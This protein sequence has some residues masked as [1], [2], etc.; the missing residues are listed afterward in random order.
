MDDEPI[1]GRSFHNFKSLSFSRVS[2]PD[3]SYPFSSTYGDELSGNVQVINEYKKARALMAD[4][5]ATSKGGV[6]QS[7]FQEVEK[8]RPMPRKAHD[9]HA[10]FRYSC[11]DRSQIWQVQLTNTI[12]DQNVHISEPV[13]VKD[14]VV[15]RECDHAQALHGL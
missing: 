5:A 11:L 14:K 9:L 10:L 7:L 12:C 2:M 3:T 1:H 13:F 15:I 4:S 8:V 6:W